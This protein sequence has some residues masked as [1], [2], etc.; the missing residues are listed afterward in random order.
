MKHWNRS[1]FIAAT[2]Y[3]W[4]AYNTNPKR[5]AAVAGNDAAA[6]LPV[7][8]RELATFLS[9]VDKACNIQHNNVIVR[10]STSL[11]WVYNKLREDY[12]IQQKEIHFF[13][14]FDLKYQPCEPA[15]GFYNMYR[16]HAAA[17][18]GRQG[19]TIA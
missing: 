11:E 2:L 16:N 6:Q 10:H 17:N 7:R 15:V 1:G 9:I 13:N 4:E 8:R 14:L 12:D 18:Q 5:I 19:D 3:T